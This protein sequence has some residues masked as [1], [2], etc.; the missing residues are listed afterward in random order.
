MLGG[1]I[2]PRYQQA[3]DTQEFED[4]VFGMHEDNDGGFNML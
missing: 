1:Q 2:N 4:E 3:N